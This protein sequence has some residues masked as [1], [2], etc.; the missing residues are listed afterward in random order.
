MGAAS[1]TAVVMMEQ[2]DNYKASW[3]FMKWFVSADTQVGYAR[4]IESILGSAAR[5]NTANVAAFQRLAWT[6]EELD[7]LVAQWDSTIGVPEVPGGY[8]TGRN[9]ENAFRHAVNNK[10]NPR[11]T[12]IDYIRTI[13][14]E[15]NRKRNEFGLGTSIEYEELNGKE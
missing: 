5:L 13:N 4:E 7:I 9:L 11:Q 6:R 14:S 8:Y 10:A 3:Q 1:G 15:I 2:A 12:L